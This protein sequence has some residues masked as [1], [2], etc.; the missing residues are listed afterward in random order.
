MCQITMNLFY[1]MA[2]EMSYEFD[3]WNYMDPQSFHI[4]KE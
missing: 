1:E 2:A 3:M 4:R